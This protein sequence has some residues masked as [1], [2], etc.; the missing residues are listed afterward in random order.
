MFEMCKPLEIIT[1]IYLSAQITTP[2]QVI[3]RIEYIPVKPT[4]PDYNDNLPVSYSAL[5]KRFT[6][7]LNKYLLGQ[8]HPTSSFTIQPDDDEVAKFNPTFRAKLF[9]RAITP[10]GNLPMDQN[11]KI[12]VNFSYLFI[13]TILMLF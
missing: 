9:L 11:K 8:G 4:D 10:A 7:L 12:I 2:E 5:R 6:K 1:A 3:A 13:T